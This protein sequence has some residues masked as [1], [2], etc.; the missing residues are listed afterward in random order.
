MKMYDIRTLKTTITALP[1]KVTQID[2][3]LKAKKVTKIR[4][5]KFVKYL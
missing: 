2:T 1:V 4:F 5:F 3:R